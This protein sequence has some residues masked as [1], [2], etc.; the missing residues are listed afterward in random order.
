MELLS[1]GEK[2]KK[3]RK[4]LGLKQEELTDAQVTRSLISMIESGKRSLSPQTAA[5][6]AKKLNYYYKN[7]G[8]KITTEYLLESKEA[9]VQNI[10]QEQLDNISLLL[11]SKKN[12]EHNHIHGIFNRMMDLATNWSLKSD[13]SKVL[14]Y[15]G[16]F[17]YHIRKYN[18]A[19]MDYFSALEFTLESRN[20]EKAADIYMGIGNC[21]L[22]KLFLEEAKLYYNKAQTISVENTTINHDQIRLEATMNLIICYK[23][24]KQYD[25][26]LQQLYIFKELK[27]LDDASIDQ[28]T[29]MEADT[30][31]DIGNFE[32]AFKLYERLISRCDGLSAT[33][34][35]H[36]YNSISIAYRLM[37]KIDEAIEYINKS[38]ELKDEIDDCPHL[39][40][41]ELAQCYR[42]LN[43][44]EKAIEI[45]KEAHNI[46]KQLSDNNS[47]F[48]ILLCYGDIYQYL[49]EYTLVEEYLKKA[50]SL[51]NEDTTKAKY[52]DVYSKLAALYCTLSNQQK[53]IYYINKL[54]EI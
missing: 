36:L 28:A 32:K 40:L 25:L 38:Y 39:F 31:R 4:D 26:A 44:T 22:S 15:R 14:F 3:L 53:C 37:G 41:L 46:S 34:R 33:K 12:L 29:L 52:Y 30:Y 6:I 5:I 24:L 21:Y 27:G 10:I 16:N 11:N 2:I 20:Y 42:R 18:L 43:I 1:V 17:H 23:K 50:E 49:Q 35:A 9:Q 51:L 45:L 13:F 47:E 48:Q 54:S 8:K 19:L 7:L